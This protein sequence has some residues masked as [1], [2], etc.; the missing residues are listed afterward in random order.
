MI[1]VKFLVFLLMIVSAFAEAQSF[2]A[3]RRNRDL[4]LNVG[5]GITNYFGEF[6][7]PRTLGKVKPNIVVGAEYFLSHRIA[8]RAELS[9]FQISGSDKKAN[10]DRDE[11]NLSFTSNNFELSATGVVN[12]S[13]TGTR[14]YQRSMLNFYG[15]AGIGV[16]H[17]NPKAEYNGK[18]YA[19]QP[20]MTEGIHYGR[21]QPV[22]PIGFGV[23]LKYG[24]FFN[25]LL[26]GGYRV[27]FTDHMDDVSSRDYADPASLSSDLS[28]ALADRRAEGYIKRGKEVP[29]VYD[30]SSPSYR[31]RVRGNPNKRDSY[32]MMNIK[33]QYY[34][35]YQ[36]FKNNNRKLYNKKRKA[37]YKKFKG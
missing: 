21:F 3:V 37:I 25:I 8:A 9:W 14:F 1:K 22:I 31:L 26:E 36:L 34:L 5:T 33:V 23:K 32:F 30:P 27:T 16:M 24:P 4:I 19:L 2:Y 35:P 28:R 7:N 17:M 15:F 29:A 10:D 12:L 20:L 18:K 6:V 11:R 13:P